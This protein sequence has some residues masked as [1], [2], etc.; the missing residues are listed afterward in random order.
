MLSATP[1]RRSLETFT[2]VL[3]ARR[4]RRQAV[5]DQRLL[6]AVA[7]T[8]ERTI[9]ALLHSGAR[10]NLILKD[11]RVF[12]ASRDRWNIYPPITLL[13]DAVL[14]GN[15][16]RTEALLAAGASVAP[17]VAW[18]ASY[19]IG[20]SGPRIEAPY[21]VQ[22]IEGPLAN[23]KMVGNMRGR[24]NQRAILKGVIDRYFDP[25]KPVWQAVFAETIWNGEVD[26]ALTC[27]DR[28]ASWRPLR[29]PAVRPYP[30]QGVRVAYKDSSNVR[31]MTVPEA[32]TLI[33]RMR[34]DG[35]DPVRPDATGRYPID[36]MD[37]DAAALL[38]RIVREPRSLRRS[39]RRRLFVNARRPS[40]P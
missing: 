39:S 27:L 22:A 4:E 31:C 6:E 18:V 32:V 2:R 36:N 17:L 7:C 29:G 8:D 11:H 40:T 3:E 25:G 28:G 13:V 37:P 34:R 14:T 16:T 26:L 19:R 35:H 5:L 38:R 9:C 23:A 12:D 33:R 24:D 20:E 15:V 1:A 21:I 10:P 30:I